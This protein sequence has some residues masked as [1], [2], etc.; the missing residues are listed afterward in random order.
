MIG[1][2]ARRPLTFS[3]VVVFVPVVALGFIHPALGGLSLSEPVNR[4][5]A[6]A[7]FCG[8]VI[9]L[10]SHLRWR[11]EAGFTRP[12]VTR[13][14]VAYLPLLVLPA[15]VVAGSGMKAASP[16]RVGEFVL[17]TLMV[18]FAEEG[19]IRGIVLRALLPGGAMRAAVLSS[20]IFGAGHVAN[21]IQGASPAATAVQ[22][23]V[24][25]L[26]GIGFAGTRIY[27]G[28]IWPAIVAHAL[29]DLADAAT[30]GFALLPP[31]P[32]TVTSAVV[33][34]VLTGTY[35]VYGWWLLR[36]TATADGHHSN[37]TSPPTKRRLSSSE[38][39]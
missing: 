4:L 36:R 11:R 16:G 8:Y 10:L 22:V 28:T 15:L 5:I 14:L 32:M 3:A 35:A 38:G 18:G 12:P 21:I 23:V 25:T 33:P 27:A 6:E 17:F 9:L 37:N 20:L 19:L 34:I 2:A 24:A 1:F 13:R 39:L 30:R 7:A 31:Q 29:I 26:L